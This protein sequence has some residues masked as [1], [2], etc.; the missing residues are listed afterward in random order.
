MLAAWAVAETLYEAKRM[1][2]YVSNVSVDYAPMTITL[3]DI[4]KQIRQALGQMEKLIN[5]DQYKGDHVSL[6]FG[7]SNVQTWMREALTNVEDL[8][9]NIDG[10]KKVEPLKMDVCDRATKLKEVTINAL[11]L[12]SS[13][14]NVIHLQCSEL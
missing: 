9:C 4:L 11:M 8:T 13:F 12:V 5:D 10:Y 7:M 6:E 1:A 3:Y 14:A 2:V